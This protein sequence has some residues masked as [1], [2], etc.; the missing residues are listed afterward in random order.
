[1]MIRIGFANR[2]IA[3]VAKG[4]LNTY[5]A[6]RE[7][8]EKCE[9]DLESVAYRRQHRTQSEVEAFLLDLRPFGLFEQL[10][11]NSMHGRGGEGDSGPGRNRPG[12]RR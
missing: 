12:C 3:D 6:V 8:L 10:Q 4:S 5:R 1:M 2:H 11:G 7:E 9:G